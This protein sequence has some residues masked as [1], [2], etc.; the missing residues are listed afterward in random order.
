M[1]DRAVDQGDW[2]KMSQGDGRRRAGALKAAEAKNAD[3][4]LAA[5]EAINT[6]VRQLPSEVSAV[7]DQHRMTG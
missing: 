4:I 6:V 1:G 3:G 5:G 7:S 2:V